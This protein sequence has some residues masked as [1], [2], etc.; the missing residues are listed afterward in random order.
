MSEDKEEFLIKK[1][2][3]LSVFGNLDLG[4]QKSY[5]ILND[6]L[7][8]TVVVA[9]NQDAINIT[10][11]LVSSLKLAE[12]TLR[13]IFEENN[14]VEEN[15]YRADPI[16]LMSLKSCYQSIRMLKRELSSYSIS[17]DSH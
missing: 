12:T 14:Q 11:E 10:C 16:S 13:I 5:K 9:N 1:A 8:S 4:M 15:I 7:N 2:E 17:M 3:T 6:L